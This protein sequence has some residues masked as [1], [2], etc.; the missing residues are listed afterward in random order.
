MCWADVELDT[1][2]RW[3]FTA[4]LLAVL[5]CHALAMG[6]SLRAS[7]R[8]PS[9]IRWG[10]K[11]AVAG[12]LCLFGVA[13]LVASPLVGRFWRR[14]EEFLNAH[15]GDRGRVSEIGFTTQSHLG[16]VTISRSFRS[17][18]VVLRV[19]SPDEPGYL[20]G[21]AYDTFEASSWQNNSRWTMLTA[22]TPGL[23]HTRVW[24]PAA[25]EGLFVL[26]A[27]PP[28]RE[29]FDV[30]VWPE[31]ATADRLMLPAGVDALIAAHDRVQKDA[32][33]IV[34]VVPGND[35]TL[36]YRAHLT[37]AIGPAPSRET[38]PEWFDV[39]SFYAE[40]LRMLADD[41]CW[42]G[43]TP[44]QAAE[45]IKAYLRNH[46]R[47]SLNIGVPVRTDPLL[48]FLNRGREGQCEY[49]ATATTLL[50][51]MQGIPARY[52]T[53]YLVD[54]FNPRA[55]N[56]I[57]RRKD[58]HAWAEAWL[59]GEGWVVIDSTPPSGRSQP[60]TTRWWIG[61]WDAMQW[62]LRKARWE[63]ARDGWAGA[64]YWVRAFFQTVP[65]L[66]VS[67]AFLVWLATR[68][69]WPIVRSLWQAGSTARDLLATRLEQLEVALARA[70]CVREPSETLERFAER[71]HR[72]TATGQDSAAVAEWLRRYS[73]ARYGGAEEEARR[74][75][76]E[77]LPALATAPL[78]R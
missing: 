68:V 58:A 35:A 44:S 26:S 55:G 60:S 19:E 25:N 32:S 41:F 42:T 38:H 46:F 13:T 61:E 49:F 70:G 2:D 20:R 30:L 12:V 11:V 31:A 10:R 72:T 23:S 56:W 74:L 76:A 39:P 16:S 54:E 65:G 51:R 27:M 71:L 64:M 53:G 62:L 4:G 50:L 78:R 48:H 22:T 18:Q 17:E 47:Y 37:R 52:V 21:A 75:L 15:L 5:T 45:R 29:R 36:P 1:E 67:L 7:P 43:E 77:P 3:L 63:A 24:E 66:V 59:P 8:S 28:D 6:A 14:F 33:G 34:A 69:A 73:A 57:A 9:R 40:R